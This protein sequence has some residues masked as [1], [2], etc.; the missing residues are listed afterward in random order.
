MAKAHVS[1]LAREVGLLSRREA[2]IERR[3]VFVHADDFKRI[4]QFLYEAEKAR[5]LC[6]VQPLRTAVAGPEVEA[7]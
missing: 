6:K 5:R 2:G 7:L 3:V 1:E 4:E